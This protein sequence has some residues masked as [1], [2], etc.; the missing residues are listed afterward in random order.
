MDKIEGKLPVLD[1]IKGKYDKTKRAIKHKLADLGLNETISYTLI[2]KDEVHKFTKDCF[3]EVML[4]DPM[5]ED[6]NT[7]RYSLIY[8]LLEVYKYNKDRNNSNVCIF[9]IGKGFYKKDN[10]YTEENKLCV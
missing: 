8:S 2:P 5:S 10:E 3:T 9:E 7:L 4:N 6:R 1:T